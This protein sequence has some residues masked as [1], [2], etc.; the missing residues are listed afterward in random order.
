MKIALVLLFVLGLISCNLNDNSIQ[1]GLGDSSSDSP[2]SNPPDSGDDSPVFSIVTPPSIISPDS[3]ITIEA[4]GG[5]EP[6]TFSVL[7]GPATINASSGLLQPDFGGNVVVQVTDADGEMENI[8][9]NV[10]PKK[11]NSTIGI[12]AGDVSSFTFT[13]NNSHIFYLA[14]DLADNDP[15]IFKCIVASWSCTPT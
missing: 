13:R 12:S 5:S 10:S 11:L 6:Y 9:I 3:N 2:S 15:R 8:T 1:G 4:E 14:D 7:S